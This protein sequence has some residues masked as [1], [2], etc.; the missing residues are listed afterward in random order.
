MGA[1]SLGQHEAALLAQHHAK[2]QE[3]ARVGHAFRA[4]AAALAEL[5]SMGHPFHLAEGQAVEGEIWPR[6]Y[7]HIDSAPNGRLVYSQW[8][9]ADLGAGW[10]PT[11]DQAQHADGMAVQFAGRGGIGRRDLPMIIEQEPGDPGDPVS[12]DARRQQM[13]DEFKNR[14]GS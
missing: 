3:V 13:I 4:V 5:A 2:P 7:F 8:D 10:Y 9:L 1:F 6:L 11:L 12:L 14:K